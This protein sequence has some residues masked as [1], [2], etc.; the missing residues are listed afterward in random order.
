MLVRSSASVASMKSMFGMQFVA[1]VA[2]SFS[3]VVKAFGSVKGNCRVLRALWLKPMG[4]EVSVGP[5]NA[6]AQ[7]SQIFV[8]SSEG[9]AS[10][11][12]CSSAIW[13]SV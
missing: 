11:N 3:C 2:K 13:S 5:E 9:V 1:Q 8:A 7:E 10:A 6:E 4:S 12:I